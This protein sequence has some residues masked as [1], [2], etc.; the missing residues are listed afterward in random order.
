VVIGCKSSSLMPFGSVIF[1][2]VV[3]LELF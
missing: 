2:P 3:F 1:N